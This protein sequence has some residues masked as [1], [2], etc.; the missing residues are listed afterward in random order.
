MIHTL[1]SLIA[2]KVGINVEGWIFWKKLVHNCNKRGLEGVIKSLKSINVESGNVHGG[3]IFFS[4]S[5][6]GTSLIRAI[7]IVSQNKLLRR[8]LERKLNY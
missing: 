1:I 5:V 6:S 7:V 2:E 3:G 4:K 8:I